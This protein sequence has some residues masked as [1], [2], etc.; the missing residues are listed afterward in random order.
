MIQIKKFNKYYNRHSPS[1]IHVINDTSLDLPNTGLVCILGE[2]GSGKTTLMNSIGGLDDF[3]SGTLIIDNYEIKKYSQRKIDKVRNEKYGYIFQN[4]YL[5]QDRTVYYNIELALNMYDISPEQKEA[6]I[7][8]VLKAV[9]MEKY[10]KRKVSQ[11]SGGQQQR[12][13]I[14]RALAK[15]P[16]VIFA[17]EPTGNLDEKNTIQIMNIIKKI[18]KDCLVIL[19]THEKRIAE[20]YADRI[21]KIEDGK[22]IF[23]ELSSFD[24]DYHFEDDNNIYLKDLNQ[25]KL[26]KSD[27]L[28][29]D[30]YQDENK[31]DINLKVII[32]HGHV[33]LSSNDKNL[34]VE[35]LSST[36]EKKVID[37]HKPVITK[38]DVDN[39]DYNLDRLKTKKEPKLTFKETLKLGFD[40]FKASKKK[41]IFMYI[42]LIAT[43]IISMLCTAD[44]LSIINY[45]KTSVTSISKNVLKIS[46]DSGSF[47]GTSSEKRTK[48]K[49]LLTYLEN[50]PNLDVE[51]WPS[52]GVELSVELNEFIQLQEVDMNLS[53]GS[54]CDINKISSKDLIA[55]RM[56][57]YS[58]EI[59]VD[60]TVLNNAINDNT[61]ASS[62][63][64][65]CY[66]FLNTTLK[67]QFDNV[68][69]KIVGISDTK[70]VT[71]YGRLTTALSCF[72]FFET[73]ATL[74]E[75]KS[76]YPGKY[77]DLVLNDGEMF[78]REDKYNRLGM[79]NDTITLQNGLSFVVAN[80]LF[81]KNEKPTLIPFS[82]IAPYIITDNDAKKIALEN[83]S[84]LLRGYI[85]MNKNNRDEVI[86]KIKELNKLSNYSDVKFEVTDIYKNQLAS[87][88]SQKQE[89]L[90]SV[91]II[92]AAVILVTIIVLYFTMK[93]NAIRKIYDIGVYRSIGISKSSIYIA[94]IFELLLISCLTTLV[95]ATLTYLVT[96]FISNI[97]LL[98]ISIGVTPLSFLITVIVLFAINILI[99]I[100]P[101]IILLNM[102]PAKLT[103]KYD[104]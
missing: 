67:N 84:Y 41:N 93:A 50:D 27:K 42:S 21:I 45:D 9:G 33:Y 95:G 30:L 79:F 102:T 94:F 4:Y 64:S 59:V 83:C 40:N 16:S 90:L 17:D 22:V 48:T 69:L 98:G 23:D 5:L 7:L 15:T 73:F 55:G 63:F 101:M 82:F 76:L 92:C 26:I 10:R 88:E 1:E 56:P 68:R 29:I 100:I 75:L 46:T 25:S 60:K 97:P 37:D 58:N 44:V 57:Q 35:Y 61:V 66:G 8:Y 81:I 77:D 78:V 72:G 91:G 6:R 103:A 62:F 80:N 47:M 18:S 96:T 49:E 38:E 54:I 12:I 74:S 51:Y 89:K 34:K 3:D 11:L 39:F 85:Y 71:A 36:D 28:N 86:N 19:V 13:A 43:S 2:S 20:F 31:K 70:D 53:M 14:A 32:R 104:M 65:D 52:Y 99:G 24:G 87:Y